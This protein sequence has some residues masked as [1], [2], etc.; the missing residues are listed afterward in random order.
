MS[1]APFLAIGNDEL[2]EPLGDTVTCPHCGE[3]HAV[4]HAESIDGFGN[5]IGR[6]SVAWYKCGRTS[7]MAGIGGLVWQG[8]SWERR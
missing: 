2:G 3:T 8:A 6:G 5:V 7:Y 4:V 1:G